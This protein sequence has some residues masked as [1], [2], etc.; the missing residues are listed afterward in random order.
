MYLLKKCHKNFNPL[1]KI[2]FEHLKPLI[3][4]SQIKDC[5]HIDANK[6]EKSDNEADK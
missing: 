4:A 3:G 2:L 1:P 5:P 6:T